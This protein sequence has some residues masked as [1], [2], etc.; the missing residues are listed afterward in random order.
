MD[1]DVPHLKKAGFEAG[2][3]ELRVRDP[4]AP[5]LIRWGDGALI[6]PDLV[7]RLERSAVRE[8]CLDVP[9]PSLPIG[10]MKDDLGILGVAEAE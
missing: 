6:E 7:T 10:W 3:A 8:P 2:P 5:E 9:R 4:R 1:V